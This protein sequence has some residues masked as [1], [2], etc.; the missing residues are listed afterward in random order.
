MS[1]PYIT[2]REAL[3]SGR[4]TEFATQE[5][6]RSVGPI[7]K[8]DLDAGLAALVREPLSEDRTSR[9]ACDDGSTGKRT[10]R[11]SGPRTSR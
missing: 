11:G 4:I 1:E 7:A 8:A 3:A 10:R 9:S 2:L 6:A 5:E